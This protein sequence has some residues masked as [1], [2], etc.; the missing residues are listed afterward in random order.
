ML[1][2]AGGG[3]FAQRLLPLIARGVR[4]DGA[5]AQG[6]ARLVDD[7]VLHAVAQTRV[8]AEGA[9]VPGGRGEQNIAQVGGEHLGRVLRGG[10]EQAVADALSQA[11]A[12]VAA[13]GGAH[14]GGEP[15]EHAVLVVHGVEHLH[16]DAQRGGHLT[17]VCRTYVLVVFGCGLDAGGT[18]QATE[19]CRGGC[20]VHLQAHHAGVLGAV[21]G[22]NAVRRNGTNTV[23]EG[24]IVRELSAVTFVPGNDAGFDDALLAQ[25]GQELLAEHRVGEG[26]VDQ[27]RAGTLEGLLGRADGQRLVPLCAGLRNLLIGG[28][29]G[30]GDGVRVGKGHLQQVLDEGVEPGSAGQLRAGHALAAVGGVEGVHVCDR[31]GVHERGTQLQQGERVDKPLVGARG[32]R[33]EHAGAALFEGA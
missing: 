33:L 24:E 30:G 11:R 9:A 2:A 12:Q 7:G 14:G 6:L 8:Q 26:A 1:L 21:Q 16:G 19:R 17:L 22:Q 32:E 10:I 28:D 20:H 18:A 23:R 27:N 3:E 5:R 4:V 25:A 13:P 31:G 29:V 15:A